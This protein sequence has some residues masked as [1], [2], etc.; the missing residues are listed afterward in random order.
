MTRSAVL[1]VVAAATAG[2]AVGAAYGWSAGLLTGALLTGLGAAALG[3]AHV[4]A[5]HR[6]RIG[7]L[8]RQFALAVAIAVGQMLVAVAVVVALMFVSGHDALLIVC[9]VAFA[10][11]VAVRAA[12]LLAGGVLRDV[13]TVR[14]GLA[15]VGRGERDVRIATGSRDELA[16]LA[17]QANAMVARLSAADQARDAAEA[18]HRDLVA[19]VSHDLRTPITSLRLLAEAVGDDIVD[20]GTRRRYL[21]T[22]STH[23]DALGVLI[24]DLF[25]LSR[26]EAGDIEWSLERVR[27]DE[28]VGETV[29]AMRP[30]AEL[31]GVEVVA[32]VDGG[33]APARANP[34]KVQRVL[35][36]LIQ[37]AIRHTPADGSVTVRAEE[38]DGGVEI[39]VADTG[40]GIAEADRG[41]VFDPFYR[42]GSQKARSRAG[43]GLGLAIS[44]AIVE[45]HG[46]RIWLEEA[47][48]GTRIRFSLPGGA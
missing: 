48:M 24:D 46:G 10:G 29:A 31:E 41:R 20:D 12:Q 13:E 14:D 6:E 44:R 39:E 23:I 15:A 42:G 47:G 38:I 32:E 40:E 22:M 11:I 18:A 35:F 27:L 26:L 45:A 3:V 34:E 21:A 5:A 43:T 25:E 2:V 9:I 30:Q 4:T 28:L 17:E 8:G 1:V 16:E 37:N 33:L 36:N 19:A 7:P